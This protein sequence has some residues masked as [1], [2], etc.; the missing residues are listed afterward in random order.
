VFGAQPIELAHLS[1]KRLVALDA[2]HQ[3]QSRSADIGGMGEDFRHGENAMGGVKIMDGEMSVAQAVAGVD[4][5]IERSLARI[6]R[7]RQRQ[8][9]EGR[10]HLVDAD[11]EAV[12]PRRVLDEVARIIRI[13]IW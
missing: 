10:T 1:Q 2:H 9:L 12:D 11:V 5:R 7:H 6:E 3:R 8:R 4:A 13:K